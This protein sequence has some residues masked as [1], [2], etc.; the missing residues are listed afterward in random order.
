MKH[1]IHTPDLSCPPSRAERRA[2]AALSFLLAVVI[3]FGLAAVL[4]AWW[5]A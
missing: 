3:G 4:V 2:E 5:S 1:R